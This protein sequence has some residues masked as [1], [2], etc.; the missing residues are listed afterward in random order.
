MTEST[1]VYDFS[2]PS[3]PENQ[4]KSTNLIEDCAFACC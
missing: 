2:E 1:V 4:I 3:P